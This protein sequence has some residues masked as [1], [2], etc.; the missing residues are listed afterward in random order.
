[1]LIKKLM[2]SVICGC[3]MISCTTS[4]ENYS[5]NEMFSQKENK[6]EL[7]INID[8]IHDTHMT[9]YLC[10]RKEEIKG[11]FPITT[12]TRKDII[13]DIEQKFKNA[14]G[15]KVMICPDEEIKTLEEKVKEIKDKLETLEAEEIKK[16]D[17]Y[18]QKR[19]NKKDNKVDKNV[20][21][22]FEYLKE[23][24]DVLEDEIKRLAKM[25][26]VK[27]VKEIE[28]KI[29]SIKYELNKIEEKLKGERKQD[30]HI[31]IPTIEIR[32]MGQNYSIAVELSMKKTILEPARIIE[33][34]E[35]ANTKK[36]L[37]G[38]YPQ[39]KNGI[40]PSVNVNDYDMEIVRS[41]SNE[42]CDELVVLLN[43]IYPLS[44]NVTKVINDNKEVIM[45]CGKGTSWG[46]KSTDEF[47]VYMQRPETNIYYGVAIASPVNMLDQSMNIK[48]TA[49]NLDDEYVRTVIKPAIE[50]NRLDE[51]KLKAVQKP[52]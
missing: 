7:P 14:K 15:F 42:A 13:S 39:S 16:V 9:I 1:M 41:L 50:Q 37:N 19:V 26:L 35:I 33:F 4:K 18:I 6:F 49:W 40:G 28:N 8:N 36:M 29:K 27:Q 2:I 20:D 25:E 48:I 52:R 17:K 46:Y 43:R 22:I 32:R 3:L 10:L 51:I 30:I 34:G 21:L 47:I 5:Q 45:E 24:V 12:K 44:C 11:L 23:R 38:M 31:I